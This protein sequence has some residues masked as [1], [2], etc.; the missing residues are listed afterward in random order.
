MSDAYAIDDSSF[1]DLVELMLSDEVEGSRYTDVYRALCN[2][3]W[4]HD[5]AKLRY[6][7]SWHSAANLVERLFA[8]NVGTSFEVVQGDDLEGVVAISSF[9]R[10]KI[11]VSDFAL[12]ERE[13]LGITFC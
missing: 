11:A 2:N 4:L 10:D 9:I 1:T 6:C 13:M 7:T 5:E 12:L 3:T 8:E